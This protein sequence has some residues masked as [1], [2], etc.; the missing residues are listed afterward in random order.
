MKQLRLGIKKQRRQM[1]ILLLASLLA[2]YAAGLLWS[3]SAH[4]EKTIVDEDYHYWH[5]AELDYAVQLLPN[6]VFSEGLLNPGRVYVTELTDFITVNFLYRFS[7]ERKADIRGNYR[8]TA[9]LVALMAQDREDQLLWE[10]EF[11]LV[12]RQ[13]IAV[14]DREFYLTET[15]AIPFAEYQE[16]IGQIHNEIKVSPAVINLVVRCDLNLTAETGNGVIRENLAPSMIIPMKGN[17]FTVNGNL[18]EE[19]EGSLVNARI[20][21]VVSVR[22]ARTIFPVAAI[23]TA[24]ILVVFLM[25]TFPAD[26]EINPREREISRILKMHKDQIINTTGKLPLIPE[27]TV[28]VDS[29][30]ELMKLADEVGRPVLHAKII[31]EAK[32]E[33]CFM[34]YTQELVY[35]YQTTGSPTLSAVTG[36]KERTRLPRDTRPSG[37]AGIVVAFLILIF[38]FSV[39]AIAYAYYM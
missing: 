8:V 39:L 35:M 20:E 26:V 21:P 4:E 1:V 36:K 9:E 19:A 15:F 11:D 16:L 32:W 31:D 29:I 18:A 23:L 14:D 34:I 37:F 3:Y 38:A 28:K 10:K 27:K 7:G 30:E 24:V 22:I 17:T 25:L 2:V 12:P 13:S 5:K 33:H 6:T